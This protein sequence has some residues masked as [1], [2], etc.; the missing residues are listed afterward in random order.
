[1]PG[2]SGMPG[3]AE[4]LSDQR[5]LYPL[6]ILKSWWL[7]SMWPRTQHIFIK[8]SERPKGYGSHHY[9]DSH[10]WKSIIVSNKVLVERR[11]G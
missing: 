6:R 9:T 8:I 2:L 10:V 3:L 4:T 7:S 5:F 1:M 11:A